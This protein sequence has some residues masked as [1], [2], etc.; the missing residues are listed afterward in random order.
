MGKEGNIET[1][2]RGLEESSL[3]EHISVPFAGVSVSLGLC[4]FLYAISSIQMYMHTYIILYVYYTHK[5]IHT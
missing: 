3:T 1:E 2:Y 5:Y 4:T